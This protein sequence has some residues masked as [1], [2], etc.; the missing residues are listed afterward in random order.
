MAYLQDVT[1]D[2]H[3]FI[4]EDKQLIFTIWTNQALTIPFDVTGMTFLWV[5][6]KTD[7]ADDPALLSKTPTLTGTF[8]AD[9][10]QNTQRV[11]VT[12]EDSDSYDA[13]AIPPL[14]TRGT[15]RHSLKRIDAGSEGIA[16]YGDFFWS[17]ATAR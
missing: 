17:Q 4:G 2:D 1:E 11:V 10:T 7:K 5:L 9:S 16:T 6:R 13:A 3:V 12:L 14:F 8:N 15:Y